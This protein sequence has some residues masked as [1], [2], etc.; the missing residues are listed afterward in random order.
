MLSFFYDN[1]IK[2]ISIK[3]IINSS[4]INQIVL[5]SSVETEN[6]IQEGEVIFRKNSTVDLPEVSKLI[7]SAIRKRQGDQRKH[8][9]LGKKVL[10][11]MENGF[12]MNT[13]NIAS[14]DGLCYKSI[15]SSISQIF[16]H[17]SKCLACN[18]EKILQMQITKK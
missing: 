7:D 10:H 8:S 11:K 14:L 16:F 4:T 1:K 3:F 6:I 17:A 2:I 15:D 13:R 12:T 18:T 5:S 9:F